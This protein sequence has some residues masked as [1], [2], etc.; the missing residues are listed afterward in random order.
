VKVEFRHG[1]ETAKTGKRNP[2]SANP[3]PA[4]KQ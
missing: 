4:K 1:S 2:K 3:H